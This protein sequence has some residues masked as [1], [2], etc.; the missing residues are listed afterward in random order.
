MLFGILL[1]GM[2]T[3][4]AAYVSDY[5]PPSAAVAASGTITVP[6]VPMSALAP[7]LGGLP[8]DGTGSST[9]TFLVSSGALVVGGLLAL[10]LQRHALLPRS[11]T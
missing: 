6:M 9:V 5:L 2:G 11:P 3:V 8:A 4:V 10:F 1:S 7:P